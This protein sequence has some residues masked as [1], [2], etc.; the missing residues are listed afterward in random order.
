TSTATITLTL[1]GANDAPSLTAVNTV[2]YTALA[3]PTV[4]SPELSLT[5]SDSRLLSRALIILDVGWDLQDHLSF[6][7][8]TSAITGLYESN[9]GILTLS[10]IAS[11][12]DYQQALRTV[13]FSSSSTNPTSTLA[14]R[15]VLWQIAD[16]DQTLALSSEVSASSI[17]I[18][19]VNNAPLVI[20]PTAITLQDTA[21]FYDQ[22]STITATLLATDAEND[23]L[24]YGLLNGIL[25]GNTL[26]LTSTYGTLSLNSQTGDY[27]YTPNALTLNALGNEDAFTDN[28]LF[29]VSDGITSTDAKLAINITGAN[30]TPTGSILITDDYGYPLTTLNSGTKLNSLATSLGDADGLGVLSYQWETSVDTTTWTAV[31]SGTLSSYTPTTK[32]ENAQLHVKIT[33]LDGNNYLETLTSN[34]VYISTPYT[35]PTNTPPTFTG[36]S[37]TG[38]YLASAGAAAIISATELTVLDDEQTPEALLYTLSAPPTLGNLSINGILLNTN[39]NFTQADI[40]N[41]LLNYQSYRNF[42]TSD[43]FTFDVSD[44]AGGV[45]SQQQFFIFSTLAAP[46]VIDLTDNGFNFIAINQSTIKVDMN[47]DGELDRTAWLAADDGLLAIDLNANQ[48]IDQTNEFVLT[49]SAPTAPTDLAA[50]QQIYDSN[51]DFLLTPDDQQWSAF[52]IWQDSNSNGLSDTN[53]FNSLTS[54]G[55]TAINLLSDGQQNTPAAGVFIQGISNIVFAD[56]HSSAVADASFAYQPSAH[57]TRLTIAQSTELSLKDQFTDATKPTATSSLEIFSVTPA[58]TQ[59]FDN[60]LMPQ[61]TTD[62]QSY[63][64]DFSVPTHLS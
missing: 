40:N 61:D 9:T 2:N 42:S 31:D 29:T 57:S 23:L 35:A 17:T 4:L 47:A 18:I 26:S 48:R 3:L 55:V 19:S 22:F 28:Y 38:M 10:G 13:S 16:N 24:N 7:S 6:T 64:D 14:S 45:L 25:D 63:L 52:G 41:G 30:D 51:H 49:Q 1:Q 60:E 56:Q 11:L 43:N 27:T 54:W 58:S 21:Y 34:A 37:N 53:E 12:S 33:Y 32:D 15:T 20:T 8:P 39:D 36:G 44:G 59:T 50:L 62:S 46:V 5:D